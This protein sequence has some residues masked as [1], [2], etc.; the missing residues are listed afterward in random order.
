M[1]KLFDTLTH[2]TSCRCTVIKMNKTRT[3][4][5]RVMMNVVFRE[6]KTPLG[7]LVADKTF[8]PG[9][10]ISL[11]IFPNVGLW[12]PGWVVSLVLWLLTAGGRSL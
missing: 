8:F 12:R 7:S 11:D 3:H 6:W 4:W 1:I 2:L 5:L 9:L 10:I